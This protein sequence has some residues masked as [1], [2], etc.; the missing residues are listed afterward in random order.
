MTTFTTSA[1]IARM[2]FTPTAPLCS[3]RDN[4]VSAVALHYETPY[5]IAAE[6]L[7][8]E[9]LQDNDPGIDARALDSEASIWRADIAVDAEA[10]VHDLEGARPVSSDMRRRI[11][12]IGHAF[13]TLPYADKPS[14][15][16]G[17]LAMALEEILLAQAWPRE[18]AL[19]MAALVARLTD[20][21]VAEEKLVRYAGY[22]A[23]VATPLI[24]EPGVNL[25][26]LARLGALPSTDPRL[27]VPEEHLEPLLDRPFHLVV[28]DFIF[29]DC[30]C[31]PDLVALP[32]SRY[33]RDTLVTL[34]A[35]FRSTTERGVFFQSDEGAD[36]LR[37]L[38][39]LAEGYAMNLYHG[40]SRNDEK[41]F[42][43]LATS[44]RVLTDWRD[45]VG[46]LR[47]KNGERAREIGDG[48]T[49]A[50]TTFL[51]D[52]RAAAPYV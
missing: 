20:C 36:C 21:A 50:G 46:G 22:S 9:H 2:G 25:G 37:T 42:G 24:I 12:T 18:L 27:N 28:A 35:D 47:A 3:P 14:V 11:E 4:L 17:A 34:E 10:L 52:C 31:D 51:R 45:V 41:I 26:L 49:P 7:R 38:A 1:A 44:H 19:D 32:G 6:T 30:A 5:R 13:R 15:R 16:A 40:A 29:R 23:D 8:S 48:V 43:Y 33:S 39:C